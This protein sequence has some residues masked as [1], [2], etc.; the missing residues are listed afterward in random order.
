MFPDPFFTAEARENLEIT[1][2]VP[3]YIIFL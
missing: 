2:V 3:H 1:G